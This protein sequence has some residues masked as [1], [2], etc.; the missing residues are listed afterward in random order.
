MTVALTSD[1]MYLK[2]GLAALGY[3][4]VSNERH[5]GAIDAVVYKG[6][7]MN[8]SLKNSNFSGHTGVL[9]VDCTGKTAADIDKYLKY[10]T[11]S[12]IF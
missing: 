3:N 12:S 11:F 4:T 1:A 6:S 5:R 7:L 9:A 8:V 2:D 10:R